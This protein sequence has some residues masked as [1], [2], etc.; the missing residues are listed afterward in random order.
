MP[1]NGI[2]ENDRV[3]ARLDSPEDVAAAMSAK[4]M[5][6]IIREMVYTDGKIDIQ[7]KRHA[8]AL[9][10]SLYHVEID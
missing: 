9:V 10:Q 8:I 7:T 6:K 1:L 5:L 2:V 4:A 3:V